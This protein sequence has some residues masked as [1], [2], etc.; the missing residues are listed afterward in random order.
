[1]SCSRYLDMQVPCQPG[2]EGESRWTAQKAADQG[3]TGAVRANFSSRASGGPGCGGRLA[4]ASG[5]DPEPVPVLGDRPPGDVVTAPA[6]Q[7]RQ[8]RIRQR[9][10]FPR[11][12]RPKL[13]PDL[14]GAVEEVRE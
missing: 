9:A 1:M 2:H 6:Q 4:Q 10:L 8:L 7:L 13:G 12:D 11:D 14:Q 3:G 5:Q